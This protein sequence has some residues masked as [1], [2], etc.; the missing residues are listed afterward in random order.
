M[1]AILRDSM[2]IIELQIVFE[3]MTLAFGGAVFSGFGCPVLD[4]ARAS[5]TGFLIVPRACRTIVQLNKYASK[6]SGW[7]ATLCNSLHLG[8][9]LK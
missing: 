7:T 3:S 1:P 2:E 5:W 4:T 6:Q 9:R 8:G